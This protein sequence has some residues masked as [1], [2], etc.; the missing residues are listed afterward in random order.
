MMAREPELFSRGGVVYEKIPKFKVKNE[1][2]NWETHPGFVRNGKEIDCFYVQQPVMLSFCR[3]RTVTR[4]GFWDTDRSLF[5][6]FE[7]E[8]SLIS[9]DE[10]LAYS[11][12]M[13]EEEEIQIV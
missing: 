10:M 7:S 3:M 13:E 9:R 5:K 1:S 8:R 4:L 6:D 2:G 12:F 11:I